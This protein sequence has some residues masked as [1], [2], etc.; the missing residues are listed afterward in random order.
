M[1]RTIPLGVLT[2]AAV[3]LATWLWASH[4]P[5]P[6]DARIPGADRSEDQPATQEAPVYLAGTFVS[7]DGVPASLD[8]SWLA[9]RGNQHDGISH[10]ETSLLSQFPSAGPTSLW[11]IPVGEGYAGAAINNGRAYLLD[12]DQT[13][14]ADVLRCLSLSDGKDIWR[15]S[16]ASDVK[17]NHGMSRT[18]PA[19]GEGVVV[20]LGP[21][22][23]VLCVDAQNGAYKWGLDLVRQYRTKVPPWYAG[24]CP[25]IADG[26]VILAPGGS[27]L[28]IA[29]DPQTGK[30]LWE[31]PN[32]R[33]WQMTHSSVIPMEF[34][35]YHM[36]VYCGSGGVVGVDA[37]DGKVLWETTAWRVKIATVPSPLPLEDGRI[38][39]TGGYDAG[40]MM[41]R[42]VPS[43]GSFKVET[44]YTLRPE[45]FGAEQQTPIYYQG[46]IYGVIPGGQLVCLG[47][48][49][50]PKWTSGT[51]KYGIGPYLVAD[52]RIWLLNDTGTFSLVAADPAEF[53]PLAQA[54]IF[55]AGHECW[56][57][58]ALANGKL[59][60][61]DLRHLACLDIGAK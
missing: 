40:S 50:K 58:M 55:P 49:G 16:Y 41:I 15:R 17:R 48:D 34:G 4:S 37:Q 33:A 47:L 28:L 21:L 30:I 14:R 11:E 59:I 60:L 61:R 27:S 54:K 13:A 2:V 10:E 36:L 20:T 53:R 18:T 7:G 24:Q 1:A 52:N 23:K 32:P 6:L 25:L 38:F 56:G 9:F 35:G 19:V 43:A 8:G 39:L 29:L 45:I 22:C 51:S 26:K 31:T 46:N 44:L 57:P 12:Y 5:L 3:A 42:L